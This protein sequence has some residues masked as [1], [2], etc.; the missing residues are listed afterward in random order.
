VVCRES[1]RWESKAATLKAGEGGY[2]ELPAGHKSKVHLPDGSTVPATHIW[3]R[4]NGTGTFH[5]HPLIK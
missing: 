4:N 2:F 5:V 3:V 1:R